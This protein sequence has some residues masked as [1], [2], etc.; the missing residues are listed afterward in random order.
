MNNLKKAQFHHDEALPLPVSESAT[1]TAI[2]EWIEEGVEQLVRFGCDVH[3]TGAGGE[4]KVVTLADLILN[5]DMMA[6][7][8]LADLKVDTPALGRIIYESLNGRADKV[9]AAELIGHSSGSY[10]VLGD[11]AYAMLKPH[12][13][14]AVAADKD[15]F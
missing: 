9:S 3:F 1:E 14:D 8:R 6:N 10:G 15:Q 12:A 7:E 5:I 13:K 2:A 11:I 4:K